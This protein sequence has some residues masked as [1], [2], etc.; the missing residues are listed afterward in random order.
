[1]SNTIEAAQ[2][3]PKRRAKVIQCPRWKLLAMG[4]RELIDVIE[5]HQQAAEGGVVAFG[6]THLL[7]QPCRELCL[8]ETVA[9]GSRRAGVVMGVRG[10]D[11]SHAD[12]GD[13]Q[14]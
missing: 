2:L 13:E 3:G 10:V 6:A 12:M 8:G 4:V 11:G 7:L 9:P 14:R 5:A 1:M